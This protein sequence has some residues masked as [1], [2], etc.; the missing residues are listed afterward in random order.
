MN[1]L[2]L[3]LQRGIEHESDVVHVVIDG[4]DLVDRLRA[5]EA[6]PAE[7]DEA[8]AGDYDG[9]LPE[10]WLDLPDL[11]DDG[12]VAILACSCG[13]I[14]CWSLRAR[15]IVS[16]DT[17]TWCDFENPV[18]REWRYYELGELVFERAQY[19]AAVEGVVAAR[20]SHKPHSRDI[21]RTT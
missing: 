2:E 7:H 14:P 10:D 13:E 12:R 3:R 15:I 8:R 16:P 18:A 1:R 20:G 9:L 19:D 4:V 5:I 11:F 21:S 17:V 6:I